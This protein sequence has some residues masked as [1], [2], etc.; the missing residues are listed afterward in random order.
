MRSALI[1]FF[2]G[3]F[4]LGT[5]P[6]LELFK[7]PE[8]LRHYQEHK[9]ENQNLSILE[10]ID[11]HYLHGNVQDEDYEKDMKL[12]FKKYSGTANQVF[13]ATSLNIIPEQQKEMCYEVL[14]QDEQ[15]LTDDH[16]TSQYLHKIWQPPRT[17]A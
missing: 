11:I 1:Y 12:P 8:L 2:L 4:F 16:W 17:N 14:E 10:F 3:I 5:T 6:V 7:L 9:S 13:Y 15:I